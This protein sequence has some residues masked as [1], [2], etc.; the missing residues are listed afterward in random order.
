VL[1]ARGTPQSQEP[2]VGVRKP[3]STADGDEAGS[4]SLGRIMGRTIEAEVRSMLP[5]LSPQ[6][7]T[8]TPGARQ[9]S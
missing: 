2:M 5:P 6:K 8:A 1:R 3:S 4:R 7:R 9:F